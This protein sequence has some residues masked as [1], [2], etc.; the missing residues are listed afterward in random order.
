MRKI[1]TYISGLAI[2]AAALILFFPCWYASA[3][4]GKKK[5]ETSAEKIPSGISIEGTDASRMT[6]KQAEELINKYIKKYDN[7][8]FSLK[9]EGKSETISG[10]DMGLNADAKKIAGQALN[11]KKSGNPLERYMR[12]NSKVNFEVTP[13][14]DREKLVSCLENKCSSLVTAARDNGLKRENGQFVFVEGEAGTAIDTEKAVKKID[15]FILDKWD[16]K[17]AEIE[18]PVKKSLPRGSKEELMQVKDLM[19][20]ASTDYS[21]PG[22]ARHVNIERAASLLN[23]HVLYP[24]DELSVYKTISP[25]KAENGY[26]AAGAY[27]NGEVVQAEGGGVCQV[28]TTTYDAVLKAELGIEN[29]AAHSMVV[30]YVDLSFDAAIAGADDGSKALKDFVFKNTTKY[31]VYLEYLTNGATITVNVYG[32]DTRQ[33]NRT[34]EFQSET[35]EEIPIK[36][37]FTADPSLPAGQIVKT[38]SGTKGYKARLIKIV[39]IDGKEV[40]RKIQ[41]R[42]S[43][44]M[45]P[46]NFSVGTA[47]ADSAV[48]A[49]I[50]SAIASGDRAAIEAAAKNTGNNSSDSSTANAGTASSGQINPA[51]QANNSG[52]AQNNG[53]GQSGSKPSDLN[54]SETNQPGTGQSGSGQSHSENG[55]QTN[56]NQTGS[57]AAGNTASGSTGS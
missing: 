20:T 54:Q 32:K 5:T 23:G 17:N 46:A 11:Y 51:A 3:S 45:A 39:K 2:A 33:K 40:S 27:L 42:S 8:S 6:E 49:A 37:T 34:V 10:K 21:A 28:A 13:D 1:K 30:H 25:M 53:S 47:S 43:Y 4:S 24:G 36:E 52:T 35:L 41:N 18:I 31:P 9:A 44:Q 50:S 38:S 16:G 26:M 19:G 15:S 56:N 7:A 29:R 12:Q 55:S 22:E 14:I 57:Q 48:S